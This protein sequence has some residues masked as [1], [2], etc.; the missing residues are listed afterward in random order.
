MLI[1][2][3]L[4]PSVLLDALK[5]ERLKRAAERSLFEFTKQAFPILEPGVRFSSNWHIE[6]IC[7][8]LEAVSSREIENLLINI[9]PGFM[10]SI[11]TGVMWPAW[12][13]IADP[14]ERVLSASYGE[15]LAVRDA[16]KTRDIVT[17]DWF[18]QNWPQVAIAKGQDQKTYFATTETGW[19]LATSVGGRATGLHPSKKIVDDPLSAKQAAS[20]AERQTSIDWFTGTLAT[21]GASRQA[22]TVVVMQRLHEQDHSGLIMERFSDQYTHLCIPMRYESALAKPRNKLG[23]VDPRTVEGALLW[24]DLFP[25]KTVKQLEAA[26]GEYGTAGQLQ[27]RP[28]PSGG[29]IIKTD[30]IQ[31]WPA[32][33]ELPA[34]DYIVQSYD[35]AFSEKTTGDPSACTVWGVARHEGKNIALLL[36]AFAERMAYPQLK[37][38]VL[39]EWMSRYGQES[40]RADTILVEA[41]ASGQSILQDLRQAKIPARAYNPGKADKMVRAHAIAPLIDAGLIYIPESNREKGKFVTWARPLI[42]EL[43]LFPNGK[44][45]D[46]VDT[47]TQA[48]IYLKDSGWIA[49]SVLED[50]E[51]DEYADNNVTKTNPYAR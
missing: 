51:E 5:R 41:K 43:E 40:R 14:T 20:D 31:K 4:A 21:R 1:T 39:E 36:D 13:W 46:L 33:K 28:A 50:E 49:A 6:T 45:D 47:L 11:I 32:G 44:H 10:K 48:L 3:G 25:E 38:K 29:G 30:S 2:K 17:S 26:L 15:D 7:E 37:K 27:Q 8:H 42:S 34:F 35:T 16:I 19:R 22:Q 18:Q 12:I 9:P 23:F 24:P